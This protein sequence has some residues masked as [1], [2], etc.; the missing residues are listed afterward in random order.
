M[1]DLFALYQ[2]LAFGLLHSVWQFAIIGGLCWISQRL[3]PT[4]LADVRYGLAL[5][6]LYLMPAAFVITCSQFSNGSAATQ[7][8]LVIG[9]WIDLIAPLL[10]CYWVSGATIGLAKLGLSWRALSQLAI[11]VQLA[12]P[13]DI[14]TRLQQIEQKMGIRRAVSI[15]YS[16]RVSGPCTFGFWKPIILVPTCCATR[17]S[18][19]ELAAVIAHEL[20]HIKRLDSLHRIAQSIVEALFFYHP[21]VRYVSNQVSTEREHCCDD[22]AAAAIDDPK[23]LA[24]GL[25]KAGILG[26][27]NKLILGSRTSAAVSLEKR[28]SRIVS[29]AKITR[30]PRKAG[31]RGAVSALILSL[32]AAASFM[33]AL[34]WSERLD[35]TSFTEAMLIDL[36]DEACLHIKVAQ[37]YSNPKYY[38]GGPATLKYSGNVVTMNGVPLPQG[39][40][41]A[42]IQTFE[43]HRLSAFGEVQLRYYGSD[44]QLSLAKHGKTSDGNRLVFL[45]ESAVRALDS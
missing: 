21:L 10:I 36:K 39:T 8:N 22:L 25:L 28:V 15:R 30:S 18:P 11:E 19:A 42:L 9:K 29:M 38:Q 16:D 32:V 31:P 40:Q 14:G 20:A 33:G 6:F 4:S 2:M 7:S 1:T 26:A 35:A 37:L 17:L 34:S 45:S 3:V 13:V 41:N 24:T 43:N 12:T 44:V 5:V 27:G 23:P